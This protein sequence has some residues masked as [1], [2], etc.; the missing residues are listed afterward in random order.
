VSSRPLDNRIESYHNYIVESDGRVPSGRYRT[1][2]AL[3]IQMTREQVKRVAMIL[4]YGSYDEKQLSRSL[5]STFRWMK[6]VDRDVIE[7]GC[8]E[9]EAALLRSVL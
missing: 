4:A 5:R 7:F 3:T 2:T 6:M 8:T 1:E 9:A